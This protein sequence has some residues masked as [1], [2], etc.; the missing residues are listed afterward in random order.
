MRTLFEIIESAKDGNKPT[1]DECY[2]TMLALDAL[3]NFDARDVLEMKSDSQLRKELRASESFR[4]NKSALNTPPDKF[5]GWNNDPTNPAYQKMRKVAFGLLAK[6]EAEMDA[7]KEPTP[8][9][10]PTQATT[11][12]G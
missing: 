2:W 11:R 4:R 5:V 9:D 12:G 3:H 6:V 1:H 8:H 7:K 10:H